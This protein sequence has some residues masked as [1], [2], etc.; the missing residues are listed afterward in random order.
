MIAGS[1]TAIVLASLSFV[2]SAA[3]YAD[4]P[5]S[6]G[7]TL[8]SGTLRSLTSAGALAPVAGRGLGVGGVAVVDNAVFAVDDT[9]IVGVGT[10][11]GPVSVVAGVYGSSSCQ[12]AASGSDVRFAGQYGGVRMAGTDGQYVYVIDQ[13]GIRRVNPASGETATVDPHFYRAAA[14]SGQ[15]IYAADDNG[16]LWSVS[17]PSGARSVLLGLWAGALAADATGVWAMDRYSPAM[18]RIDVASHSMS[19]VTNR[20]ATG[21]IASSMLSAG[22]FV[23]A[24]LRSPSEPHDY[25]NLVRIDKTTGTSKVIPVTAD[26]AALQGFAGIAG[27]ATDGTKLYVADYNTTGSR[28]ASVT[29][30]PPTPFAAPST[31]TGMDVGLVDTLSSALPGS[32]LVGAG[33]GGIAAVN[34]AYYVVDGNRITKVNKDNGTTTGLRWDRGEFTVL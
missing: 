17:L 5:P 18:Y 27:I 15:T 13:C 4:P 10:G 28:I 26:P 8:E 16:T 30:S 2:P 23:Y 20:L 33:L 19:V 21:Q 12:D 9:R 6:T 7:P 1:L 29:P 31:A 22:D 3:A 14:V 24:A 34:G 11:G 25:T 32:D